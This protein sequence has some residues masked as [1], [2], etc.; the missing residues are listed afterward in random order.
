[1]SEDTT[2]LRRLMLFDAVCRAGGISQAADM[3]GMTQ[4]A[5][6][7]AIKKLEAAYGA[8][9]FE[10]GFN[11]SEL[12][13]EGALLQRRVKRMLDQIGMAVAELIGTRPAP[14]IPAICRRLTDAQLRCHIAIA[15]HGSAVEAARRL[16]ISEPAVHRAGRQLEE[17]VGTSL[18]RRRVHSVTANAAGL[19]FARRLSVALHEIDQAAIDLA[20][21]RG[22]AGGQVVIGVLPLL[23]QLLLARTIARLREA[24]PNAA[25]AIHEGTHA[26][27]F[28]ALAF[29]T[30]DIIVGALRSPRLE[31]AAVETELFADPYVVVVRRSHALASREPV[32]PGDLA[33][34]DWVV[35]QPGMPRRH[36]VEALFATLPRPPRVAVETSSLSMMM[37]MLAESDCVS[38]LSRSHLLFGSYRDDV[39]ALNLPTPDKHRTVGY[40]IRS[41]WLATPVQLEFINCLRAE[42]RAVYG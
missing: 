1:M 15:Q 3:V 17:T 27:L 22:Q 35:P 11:G 13:G 33:D 39:V 2:R 30:I 8:Q 4:P 20:T 7:Q 6:S 36:A 18:Y 14:Q 38:L 21:A 34:Y 32:T 42:C 40:T 12:T 5:V 29:G 24:Y 23:P 10:R 19:E 28:G 31:G 9:L 26:Q 25:I 37:T 16:G 41:D